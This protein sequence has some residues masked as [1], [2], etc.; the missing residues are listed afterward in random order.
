M[1]STDASAMDA[2]GITETDVKEQSGGPLSMIL[3]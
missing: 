1:L 2:G 3:L